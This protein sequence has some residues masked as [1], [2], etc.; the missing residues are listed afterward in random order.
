MMSSLANIVLFVALVITSA[1]VA[2]MYLKLKRF[3]RYHAE[4]QQIFDKTGVAL[5]G[6][7]R[8]VATFGSESRETLALLGAR[9]EEARESA[10]QLEALTQSARELSQA[11]SR[12]S[13]S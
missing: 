13:N 3:D 2:L 10:R 9:I 8:A 7:Q 6:A 1:M 11:R 4:Y 5:I 12:S